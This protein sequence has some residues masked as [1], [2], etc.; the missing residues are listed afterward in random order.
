MTD[1]P[2][3]EKRIVYILRKNSKDSQNDWMQ[4]NNPQIYCEIEVK[5][6]PKQQ[7]TRL[8]IK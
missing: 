8:Y 1:L 6:Q 4:T 2:S 3:L 7:E 5:K